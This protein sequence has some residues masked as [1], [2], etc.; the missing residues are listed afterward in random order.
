MS[1]GEPDKVDDVVQFSKTCFL[2][3]LE[4]PAEKKKMH[5]LIPPVFIIRM[6]F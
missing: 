3:S 2:A 6:V 1:T 5:F 4:E